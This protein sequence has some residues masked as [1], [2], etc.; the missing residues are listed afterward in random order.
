M[1]EAIK[2]I[3]NIKKALEKYKGSGKRKFF[4]LSDDGD[5]ANV[6]F[7]N[8]DEN[9]LNIYVVHKVKIG[10]NERYVK[11]TEEEDCPLCQAGNYP[12]LK[13]FLF[14]IDRRDNEVK[15]WERGKTFIPEILGFIQRYGSLNSRDYEIVRHGKAKSQDTK[16][17]LFPLDKKAEKNLSQM[18][19]ICGDNKFILVKTISEMRE[20]ANGTYVLPAAGKGKDADKDPEDVF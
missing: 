9:D 3:D 5:T 1:V 20:I 15:M 19:E 14:L 18:P 12:Q 13:M 8:G 6:R 16:Y 2:G 7:L 4:S 17:Q 11:C 10:D